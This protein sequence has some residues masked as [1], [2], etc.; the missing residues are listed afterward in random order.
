MKKNHSLYR[1]G[2]DYELSLKKIIRKMKITLFV[3]LISAIQVLALDGYSQ[4]TLLSL[5]K[6]NSTIENVL[7]VIESQSEFYFLYNGKLVDVTQKVSVNIEKQSLEKTLN[8]IFKGT[9]IDYKIYDRQVVLSPNVSTDLSQQ[10]KSVSGKVTDASG[11]PLPGASVVIK[12]TTTGVL[13]DATG[14]YS[15]SNIPENA[16]L[17]FSFVGLKGQEIPVKIQSQINVMLL[18][19]I[20]GIDEVVTIGYGTVKKRD[21]T[22]SVSSIKSAEIMKTATNNAL[23]SLQGKVAGVDLTKSSGVAGAGININLRG[24]RSIAATNDPLILVD[25]LSYGST[26]D[27]NSSDIESMEILKDASST[28]IY[29]TR[30]ANGVIIITTKKGLF[31]KTGGKTKVS[32]SSYTSFNSATSIPQ[33]MNAQQEY[34]FM[35]EAKR[36][37]DEK[38]AKAWGTTK[39]S[40][41]TPEIIL[42]NVVSSPFTKSVYQ[43]YKDGGVDW[44]DLVLHNSVTNNGEVSVSG[45]DAKTAFN[46]SLGFMDENGLLRNNEL[47]RYNARINL[48]HK[49]SNSIKTGLSLQYTKRN[50]DQRNDN[51]YYYAMVSYSISQVRLPDGSLLDKP[52]ELGRSYTNP[53]INE[54]PN[55]YIDNTRNN[56]LFAS[57]YLEWEIIKG[58]NLKSVFGIDDQSDRRGQYTDFMSTVN[59]QAG[60]SSFMSASNSVTNNYI[61]ENTLTYSVP[62]GQKH[63]LQLVAG[64]SDSKN[65]FESHSSSGYATTDHY[66]LSTYYDLTYIPSASRA[67]ANSYTQSNMLSFFGRASYKLM[68]KYLLTATNRYDGSSVLAEGHKWTS[69][70]SV[71]SAWI[72]SEEPFLKNI[73]SID[74]LKLRLTWGKTGNA[75]VKPYQTITALGSGKIPSTFYNGTNQIVYQGQVPFNLGN[76]NLGWEITAAYDAGLDISILKNRISGTFDLYNSKTSDLLLMRAFP[77]TS[78]YPQVMQ[79][80]GNTENKGFEAA[81]NFRIIDKK[82]LGWSSDLTFS[83]NRDKIVSLASGLA[84]DVSIP[85]AA[86]KVGD[87][88][89]QFYDFEADGCWKISEATQAATFNKVPGDVKFIDFNKDGKIDNSDKR[90]Y[91]KSPK[92][93]AGWNNTVSYKGVSLSALAFARIGQWVSSD[94]NTL[95]LPT[96]P[97]GQPVL[98]YW[99]PENQNGKFP[100]PGLASGL[101]DVP[102]LVYEKASFLKINQI[103]LSYTLPVKTISKIGLSNLKVYGE[104]QNFFS[105][106]NMK[107]YDPER[108]GSFKDPLMKQVVFGIN[109]EF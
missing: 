84:Q 107:N 67:L 11:T 20:I 106:S 35:A 50:L 109:L 16:V 14:N 78:V 54:L 69:F 97:G 65:V 26:L 34:L 102:T 29:G 51:M 52:A 37:T 33:K 6:E 64:Q 73:N 24:N 81:M 91:N 4:N 94:I 49:I 63:Q 31:S 27:I 41:Y 57:M 88:V 70:P 30:G 7:G 72:A 66:T 48:D 92:F 40:D 9:N 93:I 68:G 86:L 90:F 75:A 82:D 87:P 13:T 89:F 15:L 12:G 8:E 25:G 104:L 5:K 19:E 60:Q 103:I 39:L 83:M 46:I 76:T 71:S 2:A 95:Y 36:Y 23:Q 99:T 22:G 100:R 58:L 98:D 28:A 45:G 38:S 21:L 79:N 108:G 101:A 17:Q 80:I 61:N 55:Y 47:K 77:G 3:V 10:Q 74:N 59:Y 42:S 32:V 44:F 96:Q 53:L 56:R 85:T 1:V 62:L 43:I 18:E 105:F